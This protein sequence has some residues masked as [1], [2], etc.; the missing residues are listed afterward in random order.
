M[1]PVQDALVREG[2]A[3]VAPIKNA[4][5]ALG[6]IRDPALLAINGHASVTAAA[7][8]P[9]TGSPR[10]RRMAGAAGGF[11]RSRRSNGVQFNGIPASG[12]TVATVALPDGIVL[13]RKARR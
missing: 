2:C 9:A 5:A 3:S 11:E 1:I 8:A 10:A 13:G 4:A 6:Q 7:L 12:L